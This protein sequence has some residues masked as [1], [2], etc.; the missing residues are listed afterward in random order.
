ML[1]AAVK[2]ISPPKMKRELALVCT[3][4]LI[5]CVSA[6]FFKEPPEL[7]HIVNSAELTAEYEREIVEQTRKAVEDKVLA[8]LHER[9]IFPEW[10]V[11]D[12]SLDEYNYVRADKVTVYLAEGQSR[13]A[14]ENAVRETAGDCRIEVITK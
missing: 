4:M 12:C 1:S 14:A 8:A 7:P 11:I 2:L 6:Q 13:A 9:G 5:A 3:L 10:L